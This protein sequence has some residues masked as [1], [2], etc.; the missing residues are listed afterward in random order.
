MQLK[1]MHSRSVRRDEENEN[2]KKWDNTLKPSKL[3][4]EKNSLLQ[5]NEGITIIYQ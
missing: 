4:L 3:H 5:Q 2:T 1:D